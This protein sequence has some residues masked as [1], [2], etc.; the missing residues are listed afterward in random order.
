MLI[1]GLTFGGAILPHGRHYR[2]ADMRTRWILGLVGSAAVAMV[3]V[4]AAQDQNE[5]P[6][7]GGDT[8]RPDDLQADVSFL[9]GDTMQGRRTGTPG[10]RQAAEF[11]ASRFDRSG[12][13]AVGTNGSYFQPFDLMTTTL[14]ENNRLEVS[15][16][17]AADLTFGTTYYPDP[18]SSTGTA[19]GD[20]VFAG[21]GIRADALNHNDYRSSSALDGKVALILNHEPGEFDAGSPFDGAIASEHA[22]VVRKVLAAQTAGATA[23]LIAPDTHNH[24]GRRGTTRPRRSVWPERSPRQPRYQVAGWARDVAIP[25][26]QISGDLAARM[27]EN[28]GLTMRELAGTGA[29]RVGGITAVP[30]PKQHVDVTTSVRR[31]FQPNRNVVGLVEGEDP[32]LR[33]EW[34]LITAHYDHEGA[35]GTRV[36]NGADD[37]ASGVA[38]L[39]EIAEAYRIAGLDG[40]RP[41]RSVLLAA[42]N[43]E[44][45]GLLGAWSYTNDPIHPLGQTVAVLNMDMIGRDEE[46]PAAGG[47]RFYG[48]TAQTAESNRNAVNVL[49]Y[50]RS[51]DLQRAAE[52]ANRVTGLTLRFRYD[53]NASNLLRRS[54]QWP[55][56]HEGVPALFIHT[57]LH[58]DYHTERDRPDTVNYEKMARV[59]RMVHAL[60]WNLAQSPTRPAYLSR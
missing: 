6:A 41:R 17:P 38:G 5:T 27:V 24:E 15:S 60:S 30:L 55:F 7:P 3:A 28:A 46:I 56:L 32:V 21:F 11:I 53:H 19:A 37:N 58:P 16:V 25:V 54:D 36:F 18:T 13:T 9:A 12:L 10:N 44:E 20:V 51:P 50:S 14:G 22:R 40:L 48:L 42:W 43:S 34:V 26:V 2:M 59:V 33:D 35:D 39:I 31:R 47:A 8:I 52:R 4:T 29:E 23:V 49:G 57:G 1:P 45:Q